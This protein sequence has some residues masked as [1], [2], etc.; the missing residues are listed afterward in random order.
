VYA[1][2]ELLKAS[3]P[4][5]IQQI[6][7]GVEVTPRQISNNMWSWRRSGLMTRS[8]EYP[9]FVYRLASKRVRKKAGVQ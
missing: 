2:A 3:G 1:V 7:E 5:T 8:G 4:L 6:A 9:H